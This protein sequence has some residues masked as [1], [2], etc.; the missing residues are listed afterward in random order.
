M[1]TINLAELTAN[2]P[3]KEIS[4]YKKGNGPRAGGWSTRGGWS[5]IPVTIDGTTY[6]LCGPTLRLIAK[7]APVVTV[8]AIENAEVTCPDPYSGW[9]GR[10]NDLR[11][12][13]TRIVLTDGRTTWKLYN[14]DVVQ[15]A[16]EDEPEDVLTCRACGGDAHNIGG[17]G[18]LNHY[19]CRACGI[20]QSEA[21]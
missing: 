1:E 6:S 11:G 18:K 5:W 2:V 13:K 16:Q 14:R 4:Q 21:A 3:T 20:I 8:S 19:R 15:E 17:I 7:V 10:R 12:V 9:N